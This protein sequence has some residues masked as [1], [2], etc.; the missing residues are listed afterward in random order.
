MIQIAV[1]D[2]EPYIA[3]SIAHKIVDYMARLNVKI[4]TIVYTDSQDF[5]NNYDEKDI[6]AIFLDLD[7][8]DKSGFDISHQLRE[9]EVELP[10]VYVTNRDDLMQKAFQYKVLGFV[11]KNRLDEELPYAIESVLY[12]IQANTKTIMV[13]SA[14]KKYNLKI[15]D[16]MYI[17]SENHN[18]SIYLNNRA[19]S[20]Q[21][22]ET[23]NAY[24]ENVGFKKFIQIS[25]SYIVNY[26]YIFSIEK[27]YVVLRN[28]EIL[29]ISRRRVKSVKE[30]FLYLSRRHFL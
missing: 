6:Q 14:Q 19:D 15:S 7:M 2:D 5:L 30:Q 1:V 26:E 12:E 16:I 10:I 25:S 8:P 3:K 4:E 27:D 28:E 18:V 21:V 11:R 22:R 29:Y 9:T 23:L 17:E 24:I 13:I 20:I